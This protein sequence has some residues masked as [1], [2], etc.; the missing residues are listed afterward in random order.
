MSSVRYGIFL[1][2]DPATCFA[3]TQ[4]AEAVRHQFGFVAAAAFA[5]HATLIG[6]LRTDLSDED[7]IATLNPVLASFSPFTV[8]NHGVEERPD[9]V[10]YDINRDEPGT[11]V[12]EELGTVATTVLDAVRPLHVRHNDNLAPNVEHYVFAGHLSLASFELAA[13][14][15]RAK[16]VAEFIRGLP[17][18]PPRSF[19]ARWYT[20]FKFPHADWSRHW[21]NEMPWVHLKSWSVHTQPE[22]EKR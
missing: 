4:I 21:W 14:P 22:T 18:R 10:R 1:R 2:P 9:S 5:P 7:L 20:L 12:N 15:G 16:E 8:Y 3:V 6:N 17:V 19:D 11:G 13:E